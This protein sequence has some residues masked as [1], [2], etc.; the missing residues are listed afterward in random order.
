MRLF[1]L[2]FLLSLLGVLTWQNESFCKMNKARVSPTPP[3]NEPEKTPQQLIDNVA[4]FMHNNASLSS[5]NQSSR[6]IHHRKNSAG[7]LTGIRLNPQSTPQLFTDAKAPLSNTNDKNGKQN[8]LQKFFGDVRS[9]TRSIFVLLCLAYTV[10]QV[11]RSTVYY[12]EFYTGVSVEIEEPK[13]LKEAMPGTTVCNKNLIDL[14]AAF[15]E[16]PNFEALKNEIEKSDQY[17]NEAAKRRDL[18]DNFELMMGT[19]YNKYSVMKQLADGPDPEEFVKHLSCNKEGWPDRY[20]NEGE[21]KKHDKNYDCERMYRIHTAQGKGNCITLFHDGS[22]RTRPPPAEREELKFLKE[23][24]EYFVPK[25]L[26]KMVL[27]FGAENYTDLKMQPGAEIIFHDERTVPLEA[28]LSYSLRPGKFYQFYLKKS[29]T[30]AMEHPYKTNCTDYYKENFERYYTDEKVDTNMALSHPLSESQCEENCV[31]DKVAA[32]RNCWPKEIPYW[33][34]NN[35]KLAD[36]TLW[37]HRMNICKLSVLMC[38]CFF[39]IS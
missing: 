28:S 18:I 5:L 12:L 10:F 4:G 9:A 27:D 35:W 19:Y 38:N 29:S 26:F 15:R 34:T 22:K 33:A 6:T 36:E 17:A 30:R 37:C 2:L 11:Q 21:A 20:K 25:E 16:I 32:N 39:P 1:C 13:T 23:E 3:Y 31:I 7:L 24:I 8:I 14:A